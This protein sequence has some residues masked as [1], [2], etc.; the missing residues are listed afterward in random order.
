MLELGKVWL[1]AVSMLMAVVTVYGATPPVTVKS[2]F[3]HVRG[4]AAGLILYD[5]ALKWQQHHCQSIVSSSMNAFKP[6][7]LLK[8]ERKAHVYENPLLS[9]WYI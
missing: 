4:W 9:V 6:H 8:N 5:G 1:I 2:T 7:Q 3:W